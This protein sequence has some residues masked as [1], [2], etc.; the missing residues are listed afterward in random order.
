[1]APFIFKST[2]SNCKSLNF[3]KHTSRCVAVHIRKSTTTLGA[4]QRFQ[5]ILHHHRWQEQHISGTA[6]RSGRSAP[7]DGPWDH[8]GP[9]MLNRLKN[10]F[11]L[12][13]MIESSY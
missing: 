5:L 12:V 7:A 1:M 9:W 2:I 3:K 13:R 11:Q 10:G 6:E 4:E 8:D